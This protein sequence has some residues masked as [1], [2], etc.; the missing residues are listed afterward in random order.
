MREREQTHEQGQAT[1]RNEKQRLT[2]SEIGEPVLNT[3][4]DRD[5]VHKANHLAELRLDLHHRSSLSVEPNSVDACEKLLQVSLNDV[6]VCC[7]SEN[8]KEVLRHDARAYVC[9]CVF[10]CV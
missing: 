5:G 9:V 1:R 2:H 10:E 3:V 4:V 8:L 6:R 7:S